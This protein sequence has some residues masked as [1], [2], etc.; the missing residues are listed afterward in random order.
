MNEDYPIDF[1]VLYFDGNDPEWQVECAKYYKEEKGIDMSVARMR[2]WGNLHYWFRC[3]E[4]FAPWVRQIHL[5]TYGHLPTWLNTNAPKLNIVKHADFIP[6]QYLPT[7]S[8]F[9]NTLN[10]NRI[11]GL[12]E[13]FVLFDDDMFIGK[14]CK[15]TR[16]FKN[17]KPVDFAQLT[18]INP[19]LPF[20]HYII[21][22]FALMHK[23]Y[24]F[25]KTI[26]HNFSK[27]FS[28]KYGI[29][30]NVKNLFLLPFANNVGLKNTHV[31]IPFL[32]ASY[33]KMWDEE[34]ETLDSCSKNRFRSYTDILQWVVR[35]EQILSGNFV[36]HGIQDSC[37]DIISDQRAEQIADYIV[38]QKYK[39]FCINDS[40]DIVDFEKTKA[41]INA[42]FAKLVP[43]K[44]SFEI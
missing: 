33:K 8:T 9:P 34:F 38:Q 27:W 1:V 5:V 25:V 15:P 32:K 13:H 26:T 11:D 31:A 40:N 2:D 44:S 23:R 12:A 43:E 42:A 37:N 28:V 35:Y 24:D 20:G 7:F 6:A 36:P 29:S 4:K 17:G 3:V 21:N 19:V 39:L 18:P 10:T 16:F 41:T 22:C 30:A 14:P